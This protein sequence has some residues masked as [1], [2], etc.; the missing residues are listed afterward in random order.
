VDKKTLVASL[1]TASDGSE[2]MNQKQVQKALS[3]GSNDTVRKWLV[4]VE[5][6][7]NGKEN[8]Y[9]ISDIA[10]AIMERRTV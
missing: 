3:F 2:F 7:K 1:R 8:L 9:L 5:H 6:L 10:D 4:G